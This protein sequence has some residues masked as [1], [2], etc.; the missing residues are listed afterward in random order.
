LDLEWGGVLLHEEAD[1]TLEGAVADFLE[2]DGG[3]G[4]GL[5][6]AP[7][8][9]VIVGDAGGAQDGGLYIVNPLDEVG[10]EGGVAGLPSKL[11]LVGLD[12]EGAEFLHDFGA[13]VAVDGFS[14]EFS[15][16]GDADG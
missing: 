3:D 11:A 10:A 7:V 8:Q 16:G 9:V 15:L 13:V 6:V 14:N 5:D 12:L 1:V 2:G 4:V